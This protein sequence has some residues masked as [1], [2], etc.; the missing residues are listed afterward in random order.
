MDLR[1]NYINL[2][3]LTNNHVK[4]NFN[5]KNKKLLII[6]EDYTNYLFIKEV[7]SDTKIKIIRAISLNQA[8]EYLETEKLI[9]VIIMNIDICRNKISKSISEIKKY[10]AYTPVIA[11]TGQDSTDSEIESIE[12]G[13]DTFIYRHIDMF[14]L[15]NTID[16]L[17]DK[18]NIL[19]SLAF[20]GR[21]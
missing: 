3:S 18:S 16:E 1:N 17:L 7:L 9:D 11:I 10:N 13:C 20:R 5:W 14:Q 8:R 4:M 6:E 12:A 15:L 21:F 19:N 2:N